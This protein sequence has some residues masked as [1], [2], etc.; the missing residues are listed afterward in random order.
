MVDGIHPVRLLIP[1][2]LLRA[3]SCPR[4]RTQS[5]EYMDPPHDASSLL[6]SVGPILHLF[7]D[8]LFRELMYGQSNR[9]F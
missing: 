5:H 4:Y 7:I 9:A 8:S 6:I 2:A 3:P 1:E